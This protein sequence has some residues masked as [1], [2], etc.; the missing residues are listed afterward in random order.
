MHHTL[1]RRRF[2]SL[3]GTGLALA[4]CGRLPAPLSPGAPSIVMVVMDTVRARSCSTWGF[5]RNTTPALDALA[6]HATRY[7]HAVATAPWTLPSHASFFTGQYTCQHGTRGYPYLDDAG[8]QHMREIPLPEYSETLAERLFHAGYRTALFSANDGYLAPFFNLDQGF[9]TYHAKY[10]PGIGLIHRAL[11]WLDGEERRPFFLFCNL[12]DAHSPYNLSP[13]LDTLPGTVSQDSGLLKA[14]RE[15]TLQNKSPLN[16]DLAAAVAAQ[17]EL[18]VANADR[19]LGTLVEG[20]RKRSLYDDLMLVAVSDHGE[21][22]GEHMLVEHSKD[23]YEEAI[24]VPLLIKAPGQKEA[25]LEPET[26]SLV[27]IPSTLLASAGIERPDQFPPALNEARGDFPIIAENYF[28][29][30]WDVKDPR[31]KGRFDRIRTALYDGDWKFIL[32][33]DGKHE[34]YHRPRD[35]GESENRAGANSEIARR[36]RDDCL[37]A[38]ER[39]KG[40]AVV[41]SVPPGT[42]APVPDAADQEALKALGYL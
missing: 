32:S 35:P 25:V 5:S 12:M 27:Q 29:R 9:E 28:S 7:A 42:A 37:H 40:Q 21:Y 6:T 39:F 20:L 4:G 16:R 26:R 19:A 15:E 2:F 13:C 14:F 1:S 30:D 3:A 41:P 33:S 17:Y 22:L 18:G 8:V 36:M 11:G 23:V 34:L 24:H 10:E 38:L 31:W